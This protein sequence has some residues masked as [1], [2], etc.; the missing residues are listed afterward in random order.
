M[1]LR[2]K[3]DNPNVVT[4]KTTI[5]RGDA[6]LDN[7]NLPAPLVTLEAGINEW[8]DNDAK[9][10]NTYYYILGSKTAVDEVLTPNQKILVADN[11]GVGGSTLILGDDSLGYYGQV[12]SSD[13]VNSTHILAAAA[14]T[15]GLPG[16]TVTPVWNK[17]IR[18]GKIIYVPDRT[19]GSAAWTQLYQA[20]LVYGV[21]AN[22]PADATL[23]GLTLVNQN[24]V[25]DF[26]GS[27]YKIRC[28]RGITDRPL[29]LDI[30]NA[31]KAN[32]E[33]LA[34][35]EDNEFNDLVYPLMWPVP[36]KYQRLP[37]IAEDAPDAFLGTPWNAYDSTTANNLTLT[38][39]I[40][41]QERIPNANAAAS[42][43]CTRGVRSAVYGANPAPYSADYLSAMQYNAG[44][45]GCI[46]M[47]VLELVEDTAVVAK[48]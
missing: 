34:V 39:R 20:G 42:G 44:N 7:A 2:L 45:M 13:F 22:G 19:F 21:D 30:W 43:V 8:V 32:Q 24:R 1:A 37:N 46:W 17:F 6:P 18:K 16:S 40:L 38:N 4:T 27:K 5:Y 35:A 28:L 14:T 48:R 15:S 36:L 41:C 31:Q 10:G 29:T 26:K 25:I 23:T 33:Q 3:W 9:F 47:P 11:R 12:L